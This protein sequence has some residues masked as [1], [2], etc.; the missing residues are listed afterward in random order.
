MSGRHPA[1]HRT[2]ATFT[3]HS[4]CSGHPRQPGPTYEPSLC[5][6]PMGRLAM[7]EAPQFSSDSII[8]ASGFGGSAAALRLCEKGCRVLEKGKPLTDADF[9][10]GRWN[11]KRWLWLPAHGCCAP[12]RSPHSSMPWSPLTILTLTQRATGRIPRHNSYRVYRE[13]VRRRSRG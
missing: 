12:T 9:A 6:L 1:P 7:T 2:H 8:I 3:L 5:P 10:A 13:D 4:L 11:L